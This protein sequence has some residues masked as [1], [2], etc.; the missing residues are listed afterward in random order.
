VKLELSCRGPEADGTAT[1]RLLVLNDSYQ[2]ATVDRRLLLGP[3]PAVSDPPL[4]SSE[5][6]LDDVA[7]EVVLLNPWGLYGRERRFQYDA[8]TVTFHGYLLRRTADGLLPAGPAD[9]S[10][11][12]AAAPPLVVEFGSR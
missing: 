9:E 10:L 5:P 12:L 6:A 7:Q 1:V 8:G 11:L 2:P 3:H 4:L